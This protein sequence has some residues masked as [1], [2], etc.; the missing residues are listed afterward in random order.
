MS[1]WIRIEKFEDVP[2]NSKKGCAVD[3]C[4]NYADKRVVYRRFDLN[5]SMEA[6]LCA[7]HANQHY[8]A[9]PPMSAQPGNSS[10]DITKNSGDKL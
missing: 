4:K 9:E 10:D 1:A 5:F 2:D 7:L 8:Q 3:G 6:Y